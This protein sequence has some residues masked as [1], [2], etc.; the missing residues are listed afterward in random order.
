MEELKKRLREMCADCS[1]DREAAAQLA[2]QLELNEQFPEAERPKDGT[3]Y[4]NIAVHSGN[5]EMVRLLLEKG[6]DP[7]FVFYESDGKWTKT[8][9]VEL[10]C[11]D[12]GNVGLKMAQ[13]LLEYGANPSTAMGNI[14]LVGLASWAV[15][16]DSPDTKTWKYR[17]RFLALLIAYGGE[18]EKCKPQILKAFDKTNMEQYQAT[19]VFGRNGYYDSAIVVLDQNGEIVARID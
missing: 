12:F 5:L 3:T 2:Q 19:L 15:E 4:L 17:S 1:F 6:A 11:C 16:T 18:S 9:L 10:H 8:A 14:G 7:N 13:L